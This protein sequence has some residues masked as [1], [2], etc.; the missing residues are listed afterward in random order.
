M[1]KEYEI[2]DK[3]LKLV[4]QLRKDIENPED[5]IKILLDASSIIQN[6]L[7]AEAM[8]ELIKRSLK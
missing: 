2:L 6:H 8:V 1:D 5:Q 3:A 4:E 7:S